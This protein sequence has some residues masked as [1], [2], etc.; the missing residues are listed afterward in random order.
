MKTSVI[1]LCR[2][3]ASLAVFPCG[4]RS[5][6][7]PP[8]AESRALAERMLAGT[9]EGRG[10]AYSLPYRLFVPK[11]YDPQRPYPLV[12]YLHGGGANGSDG[13]RHLSHDVAMLVSD[14]V[15][16][17]APS[18]VLAPQCPVGDEW[19]KRRDSVPFSN[20]VQ[21]KVR[22]SDASKLIFEGLDRLRA[23]YTLDPHRLYVTGYSMGGS[24]TWDLVTR[25]PRY[26]AA[27]VPVTG[28]N[29][30][31]RA[32]AIADL[33]IWAFH[34]ALD[35]VS[36]ARNSRSMVEALRQRGSPVKYTEFEGV[37]HGSAAA[38]YSNLEMYRWL[39][40]QRRD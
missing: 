3:L 19:V 22:E 16:S 37:G 32:D 17:I 5:R 29:D 18:F 33:P 39:F 28:V 38:A 14:E 2:V 31:S 8:S 15:Q 27:A 30:P 26:F 34:G 6:A 35:D 40:S 23:Q 25:H 4:C 7:E 11:G 36:P 20:Y 24:G 9:F 21:A 13:I 10:Y 1:R 12:L